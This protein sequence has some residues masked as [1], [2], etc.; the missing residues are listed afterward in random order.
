MSMP[1]LRVPI[2]GFDKFSPAFVKLNR[3]LGGAAHGVD[4]LKN[5]AHGL[6]GVFESIKRLGEFS[7]IGALIG[8][9]GALGIG[10]AV[11]GIAEYGDSVG[12]AAQLTGLGTKGFQEWA[13]AAKMADVGSQEFSKSMMFFMRNTAAATVAGSG[14]AKMFAALGVNIRDSKG[15]IKDVDA[16]LLEVSDGFNKIHTPA[17]RAQVLMGMFGREGARM[18][19]LLSKGSEG[20]T[21]LKTRA[22]KFIL[23]EEDIKQAENMEDVLKELNASFTSAYRKLGVQFFPVLSELLSQLTS[24]LLTNMPTIVA[25]AKALATE[26]PSALAKL[27]KAAKVVWGVFGGI[28]KVF[29]YIVDI[30]GPG[31]AALIALGGII[32]LQVIPPMVQLCSVMKGIAM[33]SMANP[34]VIAVVAFGVALGVVGMHFKEILDYAEKWKNFTKAGKVQTVEQ[35]KKEGVA[36]LSGLYTEEIK[37]T[38]GNPSFDSAKIKELEDKLQ[39]AGVELPVDLVDRAKYVSSLNSQLSPTYS[40]SKGAM[41]GGLA[42]PQKAEISISFKNAP[43]GTTVDGVK[44]DANIAGV[45]F[46]DI[47]IGKSLLFQ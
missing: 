17:L 5:K 16:L 22:E 45:D 7:G 29:G 2:V 31:N 28:G 13:F 30:L 47:D 23:S 41:T 18:G 4:T 43:A 35:S 20:L 37:K 44:G 6:H 26:L 10:E 21:E 12:Q 24:K 15:G 25:A 39:A 19:N 11:R 42:A 40:F 32:L 36:Q 14:Q 38:N 3:V 34:M 46:S 9:V 1:T 33:F 8:G 27:Y